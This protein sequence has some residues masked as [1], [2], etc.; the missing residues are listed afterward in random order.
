MTTSINAMVLEAPSRVAMREI[1][2]PQMVGNDLLIRVERCGICGSDTGLY[3]GKFDIPYPT[4]LGHEIAGI[5]ESVGPGGEEW[6][7]VNV[8]DRVVLEF[9][10]RCGTCRYCL[11]GDYRVC[12]QGRGYGGSVPLAVSPGLWGGYAEYVYAGP[13]A[14]VHR[15]PDGMSADLATLACAVMGNAIRW[16][17]QVGGASVG[18]TVAIVGPGPQGLA[19]TIAAREGGAER[20]IV[21]GLS[22]DAKRL[23]FAR[24]LGATSTVASDETNVADTVAGLTDGRMADVVLEATGSTAG[25]GLAVS[26]GGRLS[27][28]VAAGNN[29][30]KKIPIVMDD[31]IEREI[32]ILGVN[33]HDMRATEPA[34][35]LIG[36]G[37]YPFDEF[38][39][40][41]YP[42]TAAREA[43]AWMEGTERRS[44]P[45][46]VVLDPWAE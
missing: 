36:A 19:A 44:R 22:S 46:K 7:R 43:L 26:V 32:A 37:K 9:H 28:V 33:S 5:V 15:V 41:V 16:V 34:L 14:M 8:G 1:D 18:D 10:M 38:I 4:I 42:L 40:G 13:E 2:W 25:M 6:H 29:G 39:S 17:C 31:V 24:R 3:R 23:A 20:I 21:V 35:K 45:I 30:S 11:T 12:Q 27:R